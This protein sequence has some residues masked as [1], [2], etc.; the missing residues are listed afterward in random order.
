VLWLWW[1]RTLR[2]THHHKACHKGTELE[3]LCATC[4]MPLSLLIISLPM[5]KCADI[6]NLQRQ[7][8]VRRGYRLGYRLGRLAMFTF[9]VDCK[10][11][12]FNYNDFLHSK[13]SQKLVVTPLNYF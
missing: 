10:Y 2:N 7:N 3:E 13:M 9:A 5:T 4:P 1:R 11:H 6:A 12:D 8:M